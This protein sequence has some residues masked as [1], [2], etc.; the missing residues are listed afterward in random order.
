MSDDNN[1]ETPPT[2]TVTVDQIRELIQGLPENE[3][4]FMNKD[5]VVSGLKE[6]R[7]LRKQVAELSTKKPEPS[8]PAPE[9]VEPTDQTSMLAAFEERMVGMFNSFADGVSKKSSLSDAIIGSGHSLSDSKRHIVETM[10]AQAKPDNAKEW[11]AKLLP[12]IGV[13]KTE[14]AAADAEPVKDTKPAR[15]PVVN[16]GAATRDNTTHVLPENPSEL[17]ISVLNSMPTKDRQEYIQGW[18]RKGG[19][20]NWMRGKKQ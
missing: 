20:V 14:P 13:Q 3:R 6:I 16:N 7:E 12:E 1:E 15:Q 2:P 8:K 11:L 9:K 18:L 19:N 17:D 10:Y 5:E 4:P